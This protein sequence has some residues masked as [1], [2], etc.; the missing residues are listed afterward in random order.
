MT[1]TQN[2]IRVTFRTNARITLDGA[3][4]WHDATATKAARF[5]L[6]GSIW[7]TWVL[8]LMVAAAF[9][10]WRKDAGVG[11][12]VLILSILS[13]VL[14]IGEGLTMLWARGKLAAIISTTAEQRQNAS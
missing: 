1:A 12:H 13:S 9:A 6:S 14:V 8:L 5:V 3:A 7:T 11:T 10:L 4:T 2:G